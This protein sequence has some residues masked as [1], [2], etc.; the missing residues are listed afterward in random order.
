MKA[1]SQSNENLSVRI[2]SQ[3]REKLDRVAGSLDRSRNWV[4]GEAIE[5]YLDIQQSETEIIQKRLEE[6]ESKD[7]KFIPHDLVMKRLRKKLGLE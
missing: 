1:T 7:A 3:T 2:P 4:I 5:Q 6:S